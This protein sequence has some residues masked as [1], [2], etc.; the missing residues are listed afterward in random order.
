MEVRTKNMKILLVVLGV[1]LVLGL[2]VSG[3]SR[4]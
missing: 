1:L 4:R 2:I 3:K